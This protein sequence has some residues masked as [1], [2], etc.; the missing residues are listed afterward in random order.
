MMMIKVIHVSAAGCLERPFLKNRTYRSQW[1]RELAALAVFMRIINA[2][3]YG[4]GSRSGWLRFA[5]FMSPF[6]T[7]NVS[8]VMAKPTS[9]GATVELQLATV[10]SRVA[11]RS[12]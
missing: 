5:A 12:T 11:L 8:K 4:V 6:A 10:V 2:S 9:T 1:Y 7:G 3:W